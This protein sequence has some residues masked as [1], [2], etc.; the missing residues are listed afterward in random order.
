MAPTEPS[1]LE[2]SIVVRGR[3]NPMIVSPG[4]LVQEGLI[5]KPEDDEIKVEAIVPHASIFEVGWLRCELIDD[6]LRVVTQDPEEFEPLRDVAVGI[7]RVLHHTPVSL[8]GLN[9]DAHYQV[10]SVESWHELGDKLAPKEY[11][12]RFLKLPGL[13]SMTVQGVRSDEYAGAIRVR[14]E[15]SAL[16]SH[17]IF[18]SYNDHHELRTVEKQPASRAEFAAPGEPVEPSPKNIPLAIE[19]MQDRWLESIDAASRV[20]KD[21]LGLVS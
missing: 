4:W 9:Y 16:V 17:G 14:F 6:Q 15:P 1:R 21:V 8:I 13:K 20:A 7:L 2:A 10:S 12:E 5:A 19:I 3:F 18:I 11:W